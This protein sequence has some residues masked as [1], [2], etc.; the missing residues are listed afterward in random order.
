MVDFSVAV[1]VFAEFHGHGPFDPLPAAFFDVGIVVLLPGGFGEGLVGCKERFFE[2]FGLGVE[3]EGL[4]NLA[5]LAV[6]VGD[7][8][9]DAGS[10]LVAGE[11]FGPG[12]GIGFEVVVEF[13]DHIG[14]VAESREG[15]AS[16][17]EFFFSA[18]HENDDPLIGGGDIETKAE[19]GEVGNGCF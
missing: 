18:G 19:V 12:L 14:I 10:G 11:G 4:H 8:D 2:V 5:G 9:F 6:F 3:W 7:D 15:F 13:S 16:R 1:A 17:L